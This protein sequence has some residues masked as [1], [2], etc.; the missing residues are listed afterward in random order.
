MWKPLVPS[1]PQAPSHWQKGFFGCNKRTPLSSCPHHKVSPRL[2]PLTSLGYPALPP[3]GHG[4]APGEGA[5]FESFVEGGSHGYLPATTQ[6]LSECGNERQKECV[7]PV[8]AALIHKIA[9]RSHPGVPPLP[10]GTS[11]PRPAVPT[12]AEPQPPPE[13]QSPGGEARAIW[14]SAEA[15]ADQPARAARGAQEAGTGPLPTARQHGQ[16]V[17]RSISKLS[18]PHRVTSVPAH[19]EPVQT[20]PDPPAAAH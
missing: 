8:P 12:Q 9:F 4:R 5:V 10:T 3:G 20:P 17:P 15:S 1:C 6:S 19:A 18:L 14:P 13:E 7:S 2:P 16:A 11:Q